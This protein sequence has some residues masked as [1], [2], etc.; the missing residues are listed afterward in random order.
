MKRLKKNNGFLWQF[1]NNISGVFTAQGIQILN[2]FHFLVSRDID[3]SL[4]LCL[5]DNVM[6]ILSVSLPTSVRLVSFGNYIK[7]MMLYLNFYS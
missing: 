6:I 2:D 4:F 5:S 1:A 7:L 3:V